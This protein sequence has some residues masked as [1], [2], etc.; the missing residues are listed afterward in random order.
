MLIRLTWA[1]Q[2][3][4]VLIQRVVCALLRVNAAAITYKTYQDMQDPKMTYKVPEKSLRT[5]L[6]KSRRGGRGDRSRKTGSSPLPSL[7]KDKRDSSNPGGGWTHCR[8]PKQG[9]AA[10]CKVWR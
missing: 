5:L 3:T 9:A 6:L 8:K 1:F 7:V 2:Y 10:A 4:I